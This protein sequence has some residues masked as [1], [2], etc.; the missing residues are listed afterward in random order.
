[1][2]FKY[3]REHAAL[4]LIV[5]F[6]IKL[7]VCVYV[8]RLLQKCFYSGEIRNEMKTYIPLL[9]ILCS[10]DISHS[11]ILLPFSGQSK[12]T[13]CSCH[14]IPNSHHFHLSKIKLSHLPQK[15]VQYF[16]AEIQYIHYD[17][18]SRRI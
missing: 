13:Y 10:I 7:F 4:R 3:H 17:A 1:M 12:K 9:L 11:R 15:H 5:Y 14:L 18:I 6:S 16:K 2:V 8:R